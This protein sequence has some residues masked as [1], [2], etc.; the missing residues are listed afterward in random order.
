LSTQL[1]KLA[2]NQLL[3]RKQHSK[4]ALPWANACYRNDVAADNGCCTTTFAYRPRPSDR[5]GQA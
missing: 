5:D 2:I 4:C 1:T 3:S